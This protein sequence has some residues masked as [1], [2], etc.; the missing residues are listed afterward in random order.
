MADGNRGLLRSSSPFQSAVLGGEVR[1]LRTDGGVSGLDEGSSSATWAPCESSPRSA[2]RPTR[3]CPGTSRPRKPVGGAW[4][5]APCP[6]RSRRSVPQRSACPPPPGLDRTV[7]GHLQLPDR[8]EDPV[9]SFGTTAASPA[10]TLRAGSGLSIDRVGLAPVV[11]GVGVRRLT[12][13]TGTQ[14][15]QGGAPAPVGTRRLHSDHVSVSR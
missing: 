6:D 13:R 1:P 12:S 3:C 15:P 4:G 5:T 10:N 9:V 7:G 2:C 11:P 14:P 8:L